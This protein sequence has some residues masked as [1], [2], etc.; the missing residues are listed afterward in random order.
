MLAAAAK[1]G[2][3]HLGELQ[4]RIIHKPAEFAAILDVLTVRVTEMFRDPSFYRALR[5]RM[6]PLLRSYPEIK[7]WHAGC[8]SGE[9]AYATA[10]LLS[11]AKLYDRAQIYATDISNVAIEH[12]REG[13]Y[14]EQQLAAFASNYQAMGGTADFEAYWSRGYGRISVREDLRANTHFSLL[15]A[16]PGNRPL[17]GRDAR[18]RLPERA[19]LFRRP[20]AAARRCA[21]R[22][23]P[24][25]SRLLV[26]RCQRGALAQ[27]ASD[28]RRPRGQRA[29]FPTQEHVVNPAPAPRPGDEARPSVLVVDDVDANLVAVEALLHGVGCEVVCASSGEQALRLL[30]RETLPSCCSTCRCPRWM[31]TR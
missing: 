26:P 14:P 28:L 16:R 7:I 17:I 6:I 2:A 29:H 21:V 4:H 30:L 25:A 24:G 27:P 11:E 18:D 23:R 12:A 1:V 19:D 22:R 13:V 20:A 15:S 5:E 10:I 3:A 8:A 31:A 9:E